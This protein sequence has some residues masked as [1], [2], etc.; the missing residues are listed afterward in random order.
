MCVSVCVGVVDIAL[1]RGCLGIKTW[2]L[3]G[4]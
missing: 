1:L 2:L 3:G 4:Y